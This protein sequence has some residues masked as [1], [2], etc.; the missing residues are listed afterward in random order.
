MVVDKAGFHPIHVG[1]L[2]AECALLTQ[3]S[4]GIEEMAITAS[5]VG[6]PTMIYRAIAH[7]PLTSAVLSLGEI[8]QMTNELF[9]GVLTG[10]VPFAQP[11]P[12]GFAE[13][14]DVFSAAPS[15]I[16]T[17]PPLEPPAATTRQEAVA[18]LRSAQPV[19]VGAVKGL[20]PERATGHIMQLSFGAI[21]LYQ[22][23]EFLAPH[24]T[25][26]IAQVE[27]ATSST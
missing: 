9:A 22:A 27:R 14:P 16:E 11:A 4:S 24:T 15:K 5:I 18:K 6:D 2:P 1:A 7:D 17:L 25:R 19:T 12:S 13:N 3:L 20:T 10:S 23:A 21:T 26:H 8:R